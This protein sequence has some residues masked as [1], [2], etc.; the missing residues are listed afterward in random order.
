M[1]VKN[2]TKYKLKFY[3]NQLEDF[4][5]ILEKRGK[6]F[7]A[8]EREYFAHKIVSINKNIEYYTE[9]LNIMEVGN[10]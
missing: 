2:I 8:D 1:N 7:N 3:I 9:I 5:N 10:E 4:N 6:S